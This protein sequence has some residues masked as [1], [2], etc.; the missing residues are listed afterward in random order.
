MALSVGDLGYNTLIKG[1][2]LKSLNLL[3]QQAD[4]YH[5]MLV[6]VY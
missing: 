4:Q 5:S 6:F 1:K 3:M 2:A